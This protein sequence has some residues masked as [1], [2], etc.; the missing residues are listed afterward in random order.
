MRRRSSS[1][2]SSSTAREPRPRHIPERAAP[3]GGGRRQESGQGPQVQHPAIKSCAPKFGLRGGGGGGGR[4]GRRLASARGAH[5]GWGPPRAVGRR[6]RVRS[7]PSTQPPPVA[8]P[9]TREPLGHTLGP[10]AATSCR[11]GRR[12]AVVLTARVGGALARVPRRRRNE[13]G[14]SCPVCDRPAVG[15]IHRERAVRRV[16]MNEMKRA[17]TVRRA[18]RARQRWARRARRGRAY[19]RRGRR[20][21]RRGLGRRRLS[22]PGSRPGSRTGTSV[23]LRVGV[24][25]QRG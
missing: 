4:I 17:S 18:G 2:T 1:G 23:S 21:H 7:D 22:R 15:S 9:A 13:R 8:R 12:P 14:R 16:E 5:R 6:P 11:A 10:R 3:M 25:L 24:R 20:R 19:S